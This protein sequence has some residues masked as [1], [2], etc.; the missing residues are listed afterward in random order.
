MANVT[1]GSASFDVYFP[2]PFRFDASNKILHYNDKPGW[3][4]FDCNPDLFRYNERLGFLVEVN[5]TDVGAPQ[6]KFELVSTLKPYR[7]CLFRPR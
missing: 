4:S 2:Q 6:F 7:L 1:N 5:V 3:H